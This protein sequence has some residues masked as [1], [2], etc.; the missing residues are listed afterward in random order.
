MKLRLSVLTLAAAGLFAFYPWIAA[1]GALKI[2]AVVNDEI[3]STRDL[4][5]RVN[6]FLMTTQIPMNAQTKNMI[7]SRVLN[8]AIEMR[9]ISE[10]KLSVLEQKRRIFQRK[11]CE[12]EFNLPM[13][14]V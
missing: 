12:K 6:L 11:R 8:N 1:A 14:M 13:S 5:N 2:A 3:I 9:S 4:Q 7:Y 10:E